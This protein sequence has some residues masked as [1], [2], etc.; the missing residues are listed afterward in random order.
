[1][2][3]L[4]NNATT[5]VA[6]E[7]F[8]AMEPYFS[9]EYGNPSSFHEL[10]AKAKRA[11]DEAR[12]QMASS[13]GARLEREI[14]FTSSGTESNNTAVRSALK[15]FPKRR[16]I[17]TT[18]VE[19]SSIKNLCAALQKE[20]YEI[21][22]IGVSKTGALDW[23]EFNS[24]LSN[25]TAIVSVMWAN[26][27]TGVLFPIEKLARETQRRG[28]LLHVDAVQ[29][30]GKIPINLSK[31]QVDFLSVSAHKFHGP[32]GAGALFIR[33]STPFEPLIFGGGQELDRRS[34][35]ENVP[36]IVGM[37]E[38]IKTACRRLT[39]DGP[40]ISRLRDRLE[41]GLLSLIPESFA[42][43]KSEDRIPNT[44]NI[45]IPGLEAEALLIQLSEAG[46][47]ASS[48]S[49]CSTGALEPSH[50]LQAMG[51]SRQLAMSSIRLSLS[52]YTTEGEITKAL[53]IIPQTVSELR[54]LNRIE[55]RGATS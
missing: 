20:G 6:S 42:N 21:I 10:G 25:E 35:T 27:E 24:A 4:D 17:V 47:A 7:V 32:K 37:S 40:K 14:V 29:A 52:R 43:G 13:L 5:K 9:D 48:G 38:A 54:K 44:S 26:N 30:A 18:A 34:G 45:T 15:K 11:L 31:I 19:H 16:R 3:Y 1:M 8:K 12:S 41:N 2:I 53:E 28:I 33:E 49:A 22:S 55:M 36:G 39:D 50:V 51:H 23:D 46:L